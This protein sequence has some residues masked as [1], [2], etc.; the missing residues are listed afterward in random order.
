[1]KLIGYIIKVVIL[2]ILIVV[3][4]GG[5]DSGSCDLGYLGNNDG[6]DINVFVEFFRLVWDI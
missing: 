3:C 4:G 5:G 6:N 2:S 1:M